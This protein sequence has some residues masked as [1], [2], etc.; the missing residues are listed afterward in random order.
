MNEENSEKRNR[1]SGSDF[2]NPDNPNNVV[3]YNTRRDF[4]KVVL[5]NE[6]DLLEQLLQTLVPLLP[7]PEPGPLLHILSVS[8]YF[9]QLSSEVASY[10]SDCILDSLTLE[11]TLSQQLRDNKLKSFNLY[12]A[13]TEEEMRQLLEPLA[14]FYDRTCLCKLPSWALQILLEY[15]AHC[16]YHEVDPK[17]YKQIINV[18]SPLKGEVNR[19]PEGAN[20]KFAALGPAEYLHRACTIE[21]L[22]EAT[23]LP[24]W[25]FDEKEGEY[26]TER[27]SL[28]D[29]PPAEAMARL[30]RIQK[31]CLYH[32]LK[33]QEKEAKAEKGLKS[34]SGKRARTATPEDH[35]YWVYLYVVKRWAVE[36]I[37]EEAKRI[38]EFVDGAVEKAIDDT[39]ELMQLKFEDF[40][41]RSEWREELERLNE[42][43]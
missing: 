39:A 12:F 7:L 9:S 2:Y 33:K 10:T 5:D 11:P 4:M 16:A 21:E 30:A 3:A 40:K 36:A 29:E 13:A 28:E 31:E 22:A 35:Y 19:R 24:P 27:Y 8:T 18:S 14:N 26:L 25:F 20:F 38:G 37:E 43:F 42:D 17:D 41:Q 15:I 23:G 6:P 1:L 32:Y 34:F